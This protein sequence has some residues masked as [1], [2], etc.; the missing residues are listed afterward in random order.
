[1]VVMILFPKL[2]KKHHVKVNIKDN[3]LLVLTSQ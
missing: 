1:M 2:K 3:V